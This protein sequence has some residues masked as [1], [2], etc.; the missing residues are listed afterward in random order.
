MSHICGGFPRNY[1]LN[2]QNVSRGLLSTI[3]QGILTEVSSDS[4]N[5][6]VCRPGIP[7][8]VTPPTCSTWVDIQD[9]L[10]S[11]S[12]DPDEQGYLVTLE[13]TI[14]CIIQTQTNLGFALR[15]QFERFLCIIRSIESRIDSIHC[16]DKCKELIGDLFC[17]LIQLL[18]QLISVVTEA[19]TL[20]YFADCAN[21]TGEKTT[22]TLFECI[23]CDFVNELCTLEKLLPELSSIVIAFI[24]CDMECCT[25]C[26]TAS[27]APVKNRPLCPPDMMHNPRSNPYHGHGCNCGC[28]KD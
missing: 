25:P 9:S 28:K 20:V 1:L 15:A 18:L 22:A 27:S 26:Y 23:A 14:Y 2:L 7:D 5:L 8:P 16:I 13:R 3:N 12:D 6:T 4:V 10:I 11:T 17:L 21:N 19:A 24:S